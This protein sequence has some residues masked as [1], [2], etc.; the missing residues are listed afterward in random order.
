[1]GAGLMDVE[2]VVP[3]SSAANEDAAVTATFSYRVA[4][5]LA[6]TAL[7]STLD[8]EREWVFARDLLLDG[9][10]FPSGGGDVLVSPVGGDQVHIVLVS[11][12]GSARLVCDR[13]A[14]T[15][16][17]D[18]VYALVPTDR[19]SEYLKVDGWLAEFCG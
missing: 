3:T 5:P 4:D 16:F 17:L 13:T 12:V 14:I 1:M 7:F 15:C 18:Q 6:V 10:A 19:E 11:P 9:L 2:Q 8:G